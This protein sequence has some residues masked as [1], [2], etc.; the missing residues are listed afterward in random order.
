MKHCLEQPGSGGVRK[1]VMLACSVFRLTEP[2]PKVVSRIELDK[3]L[4]CCITENFI[5]SEMIAVKF[6]GL[7]VAQ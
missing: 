1:G 4:S 3:F 7:L 6:R 2:L 5:Q